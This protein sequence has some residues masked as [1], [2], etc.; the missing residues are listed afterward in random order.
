[1][2]LPDIILWKIWTYIGPRSYFIDKHL[3]TIIEKKK[4]LFTAKPL[5]IYYKLYRWEKK[6]YINRIGRPTMCA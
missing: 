6:H 5:R 1:M 4:Q 3:L 2:L